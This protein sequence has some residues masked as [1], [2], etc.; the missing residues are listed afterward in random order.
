M[1]PTDRREFLACTGAAAWPG[2]VNSA[3]SEPAAGADLGEL[4]KRLL[5]VPAADALRLAVDLHEGGVDAR[6]LLG[7]TFLAGVQDVSPRPVGFK[8]HCVM[9]TSSALQIVARLPS[10]DRLLPALFNVHDL[11]ISQARDEREGDFSLP[12]ATPPRTDDRDRARAAMQSALD[13]WDDEAALAAVPAL[14]RTHALDE[15]FE[16]LWP[17]GARDFGNIGHKPIFLAQSQRTLLQIGWRHGESVLRS[18]VLG[19]LDGEPGRNDRQWAPNVERARALIADRPRAAAES[20]GAAFE[21]LAALRAADPDGAAEAVVKLRKAGVPVTQVADGLRLCAAELLQ[22]MPGVLSLHA[23]TS[24]NA[25]L[26]AAR[27]AADPLFAEA[28]LLQAASWQVLYR[29]FLAGRSNFDAARPG[30]DALEPSDVDPDTAQA[31]AFRSAAVTR[32]AA[33]AHA[34]R[35]ASAGRLPQL[36]AA[37]RDLLCRTGDDHHDYKFVAAVIEEAEHAQPEVGARLFAA[38]TA[39]MNPSD[40]P[41]A[42]HLDAVADRLRR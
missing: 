3:R 21:L 18:L 24:L 9:M 6:D 13:D 35:A 10:R 33:A 12:A 19:L 26:R 31:S 37:A 4:A 39:W 22:R 17:F 29:E 20:P 34:L 32:D 7:A 11:K 30:I 5:E 8:F 36:C 42:A 15:A 38:S 1:R 40:A 28:T 23:L 27:S 16:V 2:F 14:W 25:L 41:R